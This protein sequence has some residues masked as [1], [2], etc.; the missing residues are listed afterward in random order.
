MSWGGTQFTL[1]YLIS[2]LPPP[3]GAIFANVNACT[4]QQA[5][6][7]GDIPRPVLSNSQHRFLGMKTGLPLAKAA[8][9]KKYLLARHVQAQGE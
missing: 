6:E 9:L 7:L 2:T 8:A 5:H 4:P 1:L 3:D